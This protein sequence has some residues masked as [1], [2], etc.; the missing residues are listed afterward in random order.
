M[1]IVQ[2]SDGRD[3]ER[4]DASKTTRKE[5]KLRIIRR[6][7]HGWNG[8]KISGLRNAWNGF[9]DGRNGFRDANS[10]SDAETLRNETFQSESVKT[11]QER[12]RFI[13]TS[14]KR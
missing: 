7:R 8:W 14:S 10:T 12:L 5:G 6:S 4:S 11:D 9:K 2:E 1:G 13:F 3:E